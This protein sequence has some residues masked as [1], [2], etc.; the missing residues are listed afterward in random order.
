MLNLVSLAN[1]DLKVSSKVFDHL[2]VR[3]KGNDKPVLFYFI[4]LLYIIR[5]SGKAFAISTG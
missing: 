5:I 1:C 3:L 4:I 2:D